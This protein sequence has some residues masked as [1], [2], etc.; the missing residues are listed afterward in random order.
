[1]LRIFNWTFVWD[2][3]EKN[4][5]KMFKNFFDWQQYWKGG[6]EFYAVVLSLY[7]GN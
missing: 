5:E 1:M 2:Y 7:S 3:W 4:A 6:L